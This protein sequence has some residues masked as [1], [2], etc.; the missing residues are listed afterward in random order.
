LLKGSIEKTDNSIGNSKTI[1]TDRLSLWFYAEGSQLFYKAGDLILSLGSL[2]LR[3]VCCFDGSWD[4]LA[5]RC[6]VSQLAIVDAEKEIQH[7]TPELSLGIGLN[8]FV[9][10]AV[11]TESLKFKGVWGEPKIFGCMEAGL[12]YYLGNVYD[13]SLSRWSYLHTMH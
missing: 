5:I 9:L 13:Y 4:G 1:E 11:Q 7:F 3:L 10:L 8:L 12:I 6:K 2:I